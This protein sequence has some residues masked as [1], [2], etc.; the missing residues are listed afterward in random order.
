MDSGCTTLTVNRSRHSR[1]PTFDRQNFH[2]AL[3]RL[4]FQP[5]LITKRSF[6]G[7]WLGYVLIQFVVHFHARRA[8]GDHRLTIAQRFTLPVMV[9]SEVFGNRVAVGE[10]PKRNG[11]HGSQHQSALSNGFRII[12]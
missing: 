3:L 9:G 12:A 8:V 11:D 7:A 6:D 10:Q 2:A 1:F 4:Q 5:K